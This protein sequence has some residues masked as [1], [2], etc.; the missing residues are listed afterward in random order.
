VAGNEM[1]V[2]SVFVFDE[3]VGLLA[4]PLEGAVG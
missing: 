3:G 1:R 4:Y 2:A